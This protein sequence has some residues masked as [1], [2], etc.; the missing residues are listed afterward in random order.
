MRNFKIKLW[1]KKYKVANLLSDFIFRNLKT[2]S[3]VMFFILNFVAKPDFLLVF[4][5]RKKDT[6][7]A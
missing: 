1:N 2:K 5:K 3:L 4:S 6:G 7:A